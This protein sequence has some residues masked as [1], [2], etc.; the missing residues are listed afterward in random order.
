MPFAQGRLRQLTCHFKYNHERLKK[1][2]VKNVTHCRDS[3]STPPQSF[4]KLQLR[5]TTCSNTNVHLVKQRKL[6]NA[7]AIDD[8][9]QRKRQKVASHSEVSKLAVS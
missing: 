4:P 6:A 7:S 2:I 5:V 9:Y 3:L 8:K 1:S